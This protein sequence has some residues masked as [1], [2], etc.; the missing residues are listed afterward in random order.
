MFSWLI[1]RNYLGST[2]SALSLNEC[3]WESSRERY[4]L[5]LQTHMHQIV[6]RNMKTSFSENYDTTIIS[7]ENVKNS[8]FRI[9]MHITI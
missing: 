1:L 4:L 3:N 9:Q 7:H 5:F 2:G 8:G 6:G